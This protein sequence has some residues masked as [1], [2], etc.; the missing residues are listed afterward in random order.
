LFEVI[1]GTFGTTSPFTDL[2]PGDRGTVDFI[3][4]MGTVF[5]NWDRGSTLGQEK[6]VIGRW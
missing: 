5:V 1:N 3:D 2:K 4:D 6:E